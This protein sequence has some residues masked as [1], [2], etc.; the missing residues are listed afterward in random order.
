MN[1][2]QIAG[3][4]EINPHMA[5]GLSESADAHGDL[6]WLRWCAVVEKLLGHDLDGDEQK[7][8]YS[9]DY[10]CEFWASGGTPADYAA[11]VKSRPNYR[12]A[13]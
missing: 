2:A 7:N 11:A 10:A 5:L 8:G 9:I 4:A 12:V 1:R 3:L 6:A 13:Q